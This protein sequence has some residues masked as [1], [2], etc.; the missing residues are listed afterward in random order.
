MAVA[1]KTT[2]AKTT[3]AKT[4]GRNIITRIPLLLC[5]AEQIRASAR[6]ALPRSAQ[7]RPS[8]LAAGGVAAAILLLTAAAALAKPPAPALIKA[9]LLLPPVTPACVSSPFGP[10]ILADR[11]L[12]GTYHYGIDLPAPEG[13]P[14]HVVAPGTVIRV[15]RHGPGG[16]EMLVQHPGFVAVYSHLGM[17]APRIAEG[18][19]E[20]AGGEKIGVVG[21][22][23]VTYGMHLYFGMFVNGRPV[24]PTKYL[25]VAPG[26]SPAA[27]SATKV[28]DGRVPPTRIYAGG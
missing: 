19:R 26:G 16:L 13:A 15:Q 20:L 10:R 24:D 4:A 12:A 1:G 21:H 7:C 9:P 8:G 11:P 2:T 3:T 25:G 22:S 28:M 14:V 27:A 5:F 23:G 18:R 17:I 6:S